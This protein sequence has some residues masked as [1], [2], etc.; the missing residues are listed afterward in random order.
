MKKMKFTAIDLFCGCGGFSEGFMQTEKFDIPVHID[1]EEAPLNTLRHRLKT[2]WKHQEPSQSVLKYDL[3]NIDEILNG[4]DAEK[5]QHFYSKNGIGKLFKKGEL[6]FV[7]GGPPCQAYSIAGRVRCPDGMKN[8]YRNFLFESYVK[9]V[10]HFKPKMFI[11]ENVPGMLSASPGGISI[12]DRIKKSF[13][14]IDYEIVD[15][16]KSAVFN[17]S[18][19]G[20]PQDRRRVIILGVSKNFFGAKISKEIIHNF[21]YEIMPSLKQAVHNTVRDAISH[22]PRLVINKGENKH[23]ISHNVNEYFPNHTP[24]FHSERD[25]EIFKLLAKD[26]QRKIR[27]YDSTDDLKAL[28]TKVTGKKSNVHKYCVQEWDKPSKTIVAHLYKDGLRHIHPDPSQGRSLTVRECA[29]LQTF[30]DDFIFTESM[31][32]NYKMIGNAVPPVFSKL[33]ATVTSKQLEYYISLR[34]GRNITRQENLSL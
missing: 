32:A 23:K 28:Y 11:F 16:F 31:G 9:M 12:V 27:E 10:D 24:R 21:Y 3:Q 29:A 5:Y 34:G 19:Y 26:K 25:I 7:I 30:P 4:W 18:D 20:V 8:D 17:T 2:K 6:D 22:Y 15:D 14:E 33:L 13:S 1:W